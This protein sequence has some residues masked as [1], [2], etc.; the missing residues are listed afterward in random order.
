MDK[1]NLAEFPKEGLSKNPV[2]VTYFQKV[3]VAAS[4]LNVK[5]LFDS[6]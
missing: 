4:N 2:N 1:K 6:K 3:Y 5:N